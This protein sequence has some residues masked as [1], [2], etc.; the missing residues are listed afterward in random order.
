MDQ[1]AE[2]A[3]RGGTP[4]PPWHLASE[5]RRLFTLRQLSL[6]PYQDSCFFAEAL[7]D[8]MAAS[9]CT[10]LGTQLYYPL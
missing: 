7:M 5:E 4:P 1:P 2:V 9:A 6:G 3:G 10:D 8:V